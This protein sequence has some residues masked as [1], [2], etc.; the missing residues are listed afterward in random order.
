MEQKNAVIKS[1][2]LTIADHGLLT[3]WLHLDYEDC[4]QGFGGYVLY[5]PKTFDHHKLYS[6]A[7]HWIF[8][9]LEI[10]GVEE[11]SKLPGRTIR[12]RA[13]YDCVHA[14]GHIIKDEWFNPRE[15]FAAIIEAAKKTDDPDPED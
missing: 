11:W 1:T 10:A 8:R 15:D 2:E 4:S 3:G 13:E 9:V 14:I 12:V 5:L 6:L 7:G